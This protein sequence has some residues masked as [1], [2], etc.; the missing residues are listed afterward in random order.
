MKSKVAARVHLFSA[1]LTLAILVGLAGCSGTTGSY[2]NGGMDTPTATTKYGKLYGEFGLNTDFTPDT[3]NFKDVT[4]K[5]TSIERS[6]NLLSVTVQWTSLKDGATPAL[7]QNMTVYDDAG[8]ECK[9]S[10]GL[11]TGSE[12]LKKGASDSYVVL[13]E[14]RSNVS[15][16]ELSLSDEFNEPMSSFGISVDEETGKAAQE[17]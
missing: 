1:V 5:I 15:K 8:H 2:S 7:A 6:R 4:Y 13:Y 12:K 9:L 14:Y 16:Y 10:S 3:P 11:E 17:K